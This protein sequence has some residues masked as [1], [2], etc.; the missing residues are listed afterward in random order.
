[1][2]A[3]TGG[4]SLPSPIMRGAE[5]EVPCQFYVSFPQRKVF[6]QGERDGILGL[7]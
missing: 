6:P 5:G 1:V 4:A 7:K 2:R 3:A